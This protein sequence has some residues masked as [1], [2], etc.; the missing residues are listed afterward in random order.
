VNYHRGL[1]FWGL[2][3]ITGGAVALAAQGGYIDRDW[4]AG[5]WRLWPLILIAI[6]VSILGSRTPFAI[7]GTVLA[8]L[9]VGSA[10]GVLIAVGPAVAACGAAEPIELHAEQGTFGDAAQVTLDFDC[11]VLAVGTGGHGDQW[12]VISGRQGGDPARITADRDRL[13][14]ESSENAGWWSGGRQQWMVRLPAAT[15][16]DLEITAN[17]AQSRFL[18]GDGRFASLALHSNAGSLTLDLSGARISDLDLSVN[19]GSAS[20]LVGDGDLAG[21]MTVN[22]GSLELCNTSAVQ[23][24][25]RIHDNITFSNNLAESGFSRHGDIWSYA[26]LVAPGTGLSF[27]DLRIEGNAAS[28]TLNPPAGCVAGQK[29]GALPDRHEIGDLG[30][31]S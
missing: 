4:L 25:L 12:N 30:G 26:P 28:L 15:R 23:W 24:R 7:A 3:L 14:V 18:L 31:A 19:A 5:A 16:Y 2:A 13:R 22:A 9:V 21:S 29:E 17:A 1:L 8:A 11:G 6:G 20:I 10:G 27:V